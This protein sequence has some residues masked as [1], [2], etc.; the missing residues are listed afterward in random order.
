MT[1]RATT[2]TRRRGEGGSL[3][4]LRASVSPWCRSGSQA[5]ELANEGDLLGAVAVPGDL[6]EVDHGGV[7]ELVHHGRGGRV[8]GLLLLRGQRTQALLRALQL[9]LADLLGPLAQ[10]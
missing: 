10:L 5:E 3:S 8:Q 9:A 4:F 6:L 7:Q 1:A 2:E